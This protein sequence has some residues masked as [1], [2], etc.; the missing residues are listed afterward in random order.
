MLGYCSSARC[1]LQVA[2]ATAATSATTE[3]AITISAVDDTSNGKYHFEFTSNAAGTYALDFAVL[4]GV[5]AAG[6]AAA[7]LPSC[8][9]VVLK[10]ASMPTVTVHPGVTS[11]ASSLPI[12]V[13]VINGAISALQSASADAPETVTVYMLAKDSYGNIQLSTVVDVF[14]VTWPAGIDG[15][16]DALTANFAAVDCTVTDCDAD[17]RGYGR[18]ADVVAAHSEAGKPAVYSYTM[19]AP[20]PTTE[21]ITSAAK[22]DLV[23]QDA[24]EEA[25]L[26]ETPV[27][28]I[29]VSAVATASAAS[30]MVGSP[31]GVVSAAGIKLI[32]GVEAALVVTL[33]SDLGIELT[34]DKTA[35]YGTLSATVEDADGVEIVGAVTKA[36]Y[37][38]A[39]ADIA[40]SLSLTSTTGSYVLKLALGGTP[41]G[42]YEGLSEAP[43]QSIPIAVA[44]APASSESTSVVFGAPAADVAAGGAVGFKMQSKD[45]YGNNQ[46]ASIKDVYFVS[47][48]KDTLPPC[49]DAITWAAPEVQGAGGLYEVAQTVTLAGRY[50]CSV[51]MLVGV[52]SVPLVTDGSDVSVVVNVVP[53]PRKPASSSVV[54]NHARGTQ[55]AGAPIDVQVLL[56]DEH[57][58]PTTNTPVDANGQ[59]IKPESYLELKWFDDACVGVSCTA[60]TGGDVPS[61]TLLA[62]TVGYVISGSITQAKRYKL[63]VKFKRDS[64]TSVVM[65]RTGLVAR[66]P[67]LTIAAGPVS[68]AR[69]TVAVP[70]ITAEATSLVAGAPVSVVVETKDAYDNPTV[71]GASSLK[72]IL[73]HGDGAGAGDDADL[74]NFL[75]LSPADLFAADLAR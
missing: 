26:A 67:V 75:H 62:G 13:D 21:T 22:V 5:T 28:F 37:S 15:A 6:A 64:D 25:V 50:T 14:A 68:S 10:H 16:S 17:I 61:A 12:G 70:T 41:I 3:G 7:T 27:S 52:E 48:C 39:G 1:S 46:Q 23:K 33:V 9:G 30:S 72:V 53:G 29:S 45:T 31:Q 74:E 4:P 57:G 44:P 38:G 55:T 40:L 32:A 56:R 49:A 42:R 19:A 51:G 58:N 43:P 47:C 59:A 20:G 54:I 73:A 8:I 34:G 71:I 60:L 66:S 63:Q 18:A 36:A 65:D 35:E 24:T 2:A 11:G 69:S